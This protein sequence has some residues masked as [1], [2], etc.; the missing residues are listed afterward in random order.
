MDYKRRWTAFI[1]AVVLCLFLAATALLAAGCGEGEEKKP[2]DG[3]TEEKVEPEGGEETAAGGEKVLLV[4]APVDFQDVEYRGTRQMLE[5]GG[6]EVVVASRSVEPCKGMDGLE[7]TPDVSLQEVQVGDYAAVAF[8][9]GGGAAVYFDDPA[10]LEI[11]RGAYE[12]GLTVGAIC[13]AP[14]ILARAGILEG[15]KATVFASEAE[16]LEK[17]GAV[18]TGA[19]VETDG[20]VVTAAGP[21]ACYEF[22]RALVLNIG[23]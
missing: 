3:T 12:E 7:V 13:I 8:I 15:K 20:K 21:Q 17:A 19:E 14:V 4:I 11:A 18:Y 5:E 1:L 6:Y 22:G 23:E 10:A 9:G 2:P 16:E